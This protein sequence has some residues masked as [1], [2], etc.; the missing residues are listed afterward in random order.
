MKAS[1]VVPFTQHLLYGRG[2]IHDWSNASTSFFPNLVSICFT[3]DVLIG[4]MQPYLLLTAAVV[5]LLYSISGPVINF[6]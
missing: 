1:T 5:E 2:V 3:R 6:F 4:R